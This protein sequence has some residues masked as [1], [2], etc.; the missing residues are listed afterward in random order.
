VDPIVLIIVLA[1][2]GPL[3]I[4]W[5]LSKSASLRGPAP[6]ARESRKPVSDLVTDVVPEEQPE[7][8]EDD[9]ERD[10]R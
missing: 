8:D 5:A 4:V 10:G 1:V 9:E 3:G 6:R 2:G 7:D